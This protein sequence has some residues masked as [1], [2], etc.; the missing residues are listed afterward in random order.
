VEQVSAH[1][2]VTDGSAVGIRAEANERSAR[3][4]TLASMVVVCDVTEVEWKEVTRSD[5]IGL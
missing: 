2:G 5:A 4:A 3:A 1:A